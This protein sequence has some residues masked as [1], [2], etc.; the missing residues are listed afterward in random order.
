[1]SESVTSK[2]LDKAEVA[3]AC[4]NQFSEEQMKSITFGLRV[5]SLLAKCPNILDDEYDSNSV[6][7]LNLY[8]KVQCGEVLSEITL[9]RALALVELR[10]KACNIS[11]NDDTLDEGEKHFV[12]ASGFWTMSGGNLYIAVANILD[13]DK[14]FV[15]LT[16]LNGTEYIKTAKANHTSSRIDLTFANTPANSN[17]KAQWMVIR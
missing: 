2:W 9:L 4:G 12:F 8:A 3:L 5:R 10:E 1:M 16:D 13:T 14:V 17:T 6:N 15:Q 11:I 7:I